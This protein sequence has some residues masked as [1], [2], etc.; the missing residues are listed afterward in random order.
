MF[1]FVFYGIEFTTKEIVQ[2]RFCSKAY[3]QNDASKING[4]RLRKRNR[5]ICKVRKV[6]VRDLKPAHIYPATAYQLSKEDWVSPYYRGRIFII[7]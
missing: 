2:K 5:N 1:I 3:T 7:E 6:L 4:R